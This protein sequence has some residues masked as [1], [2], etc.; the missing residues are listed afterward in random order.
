MSKIPRLDMSITFSDSDM[1]GCQHP[2]DDPLVVRAVVANKTVHRDL[3]DN[4][5]SVDIIFASSFDKWA[6]EG[7][8]W[9]PSTL[10]CGDSLGKRYYL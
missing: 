7:R 9:N 3:I 5:S 4:G 1:E 8:N 6:S 10:I 2:H